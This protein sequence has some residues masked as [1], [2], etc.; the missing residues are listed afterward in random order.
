MTRLVQKTPKGG[1]QA[2]FSICAGVTVDSDTY[3]TQP[4]QNTVRQKLR[5]GATTHPKRPN[6][7]WDRDGNARAR[8]KLKTVR[9]T[10]CTIPK[11]R[12]MEY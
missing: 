12:R 7:K 1:I 2:V 11:V 4:L 9:R 6:R 3:S 10:A 5:R 8:Q